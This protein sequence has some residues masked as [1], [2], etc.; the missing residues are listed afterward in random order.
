MNKSF[1][2]IFLESIS[3][4]RKTLLTLIWVY[5]VWVFFV[6]IC[7]SIASLM[8]GKEIFTILFASIKNPASLNVTKEQ[9]L[10][11][12]L[13]GLFVLGT[14]YLTCFWAILII[15]NKILLGQSLIIETFIEC[16][17]KLW[18]IIFVNIILVVID[19]A[20]LFISILLL[21]KWYSI[22]F[23]PFFFFLGPMWFTSVYGVICQNGKFWKIVAQ[24]VSLAYHNWL[25]ITIKIILLQ[26]TLVLLIILLTCFNFI[27][28]V[29][30]INI[31]VNLTEALFT[32]FIATF[33]PCF[34]T[35]LYL[36]IA[37]IKPQNENLIGT[38]QINQSQIMP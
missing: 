8:G 11:V 12:F 30:E 18:R 16:C 24:N 19:F 25:N 4:L 10:P 36:N 29:I 1:K 31:V 3:V 32:V 34:A 2:A 6:S 35:V 38:N 9:A 14:F 37:G 20:A 26:L 7:G 28:R 27:F 5:L 22:I 21:G 13:W 33:L 15:R 17:R 23:I